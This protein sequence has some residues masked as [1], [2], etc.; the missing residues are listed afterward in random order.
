MK[1]RSKIILTAIA[2][3]LLLAACG[4]LIF[5]NTEVSLDKILPQEQW[6]DVSVVAAVFEDGEVRH[7]AYMVEESVS[8]QL[9]QALYSGRA[10]R[11]RS[12]DSMHADLLWLVIWTGKDQGMWNLSLGENGLLLITSPDL[13][14][15]YFENCQELYWQ[16]QD[17][18]R[19]LPLAE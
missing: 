9:R 2:A 7:K 13:H 5:M 16:I 1:K 4:F 14:N 6:M 10:E 18:V 17:I 8:G 12:F 11:R 3:F 19:E 15:Y